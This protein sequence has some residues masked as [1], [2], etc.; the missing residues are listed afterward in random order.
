MCHLI[1]T[2]L[3][4]KARARMAVSVIVK[5]LIPLDFTF[6]GRNNISNVEI[7]CA[8][9][10]SQRNCIYGNSTASSRG[11]KTGMRGHIDSPG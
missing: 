2:N 4:Y 9:A 1:H 7:Y 10:R 8:S 6:T 3:K 5:I 11:G